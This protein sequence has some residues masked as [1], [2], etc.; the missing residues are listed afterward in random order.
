[1]EQRYPNTLVRKQN[2]VVISGVTFFKYTSCAEHRIALSLVENRLQ[3]TLVVWNTEL[4][5]HC[6]RNGF[7]LHFLCEA[8]NC[9][10]AVRS[11]AFN[12][13]CCPK[14]RIAFS[15][16]EKLLSITL[17][18]IKQLRCHSCCNGFQL[19]LLCDAQNC[20]AT[21]GA[22]A[23]NYTCCAKHRIAFSLVEQRLRIKLVV[24]NTELRCHFCCKGYKIYLCEKEN[25]VVPG[26]AMDFNYTWYAKHRIASSLLEQRLSLTIVRSSALRCRWWSHGL[27]LHVLC[28]ELRFLWWS[29]GF[30]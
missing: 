8:Q 9:V 20:V 4:S 30:N 1:V 10:F 21:G 24:L 6:S 25:C 15:L 11:T 14:H 26:V 3:I 18:G 2:C 7:Q 27:Q 28:E 13:T 22:T 5:C 23:Y 19:Q 29:N 17:V 16:V 12:Y